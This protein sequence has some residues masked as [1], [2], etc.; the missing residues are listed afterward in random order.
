[1]HTGF[2]QLRSR[3]GQLQLSFWWQCLITGAVV[4]NTYRSKLMSGTR[5]QRGCKQDLIIHSAAWPQWPKD[6]LL[7]FTSWSIWEPRFSK[8]GGMVNESHC[9][10]SRKQIHSS[11]PSKNSLHLSFLQKILANLPWSQV[12]SNFSKAGKIKEKTKCHFQD[13]LNNRL[14]GKPLSEQTDANNSTTACLAN[15]WPVVPANP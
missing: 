11:M 12:L 9:F 2:W 7:S 10:H 14:T 5:K 8:Q 13:E 6:L 15:W 4:R 3:I 1:M